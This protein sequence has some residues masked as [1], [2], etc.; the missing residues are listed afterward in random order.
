METLESTPAEVDVAPG[1]DEAVSVTETQAESQAASL[2]DEGDWVC[3]R[4]AASEALEVYQATKGD[5]NAM[6]VEARIIAIRTPQ[7]D[8]RTEDGIEYLNATYDPLL[9]QPRT[10]AVGPDPAVVSAG[11]G[12]CG[13]G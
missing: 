12:G 6:R 8:V 2:A 1:A 7:A 9:S 5:P 11:C 13:V 10:W 3:Y 4:R